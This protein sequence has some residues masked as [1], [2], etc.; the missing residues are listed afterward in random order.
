[1]TM[2]DS[3]DPSLG[4][5]VVSGTKWRDLASEKAEEEYYTE[6]DIDVVRFDPRD[7][8][9]SGTEEVLQALLE[10]A[11]VPARG[12]MRTDFGGELPPP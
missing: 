12:T 6:L 9:Y 2:R 4:A 8:S 1:M 5:T 3:S 7:E 10:L 11:G